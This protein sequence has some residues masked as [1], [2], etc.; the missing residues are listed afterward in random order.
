MPKIRDLTNC[1]FGRLVAIRLTGEIRAHKAMW[2]CRC[3]C[4]NLCEIAGVSLTRG[5]TRSCG[6]LSIEKL[7]ARKGPLSS[8][9][10]RSGPLSSM[11]GRFGPL[12]PR[13]NPELTKEDRQDK[14]RYTEY[15]A[16][17]TSVYKRDNFTCQKCGDSIGG[18]LNAH[19]IRGYTKNPAL[20]TK[21]ENG[22]TLC[23]EC[24][25]DYHHCYGHSGG[26]KEFEKWMK[27]SPIQN[28][29]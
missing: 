5:S 12:S 20:R 27:L 14:R 9:W 3:S 7:K 24:H 8:N 28:S 17:R 6:C 16:W 21:I 18:S 10:G 19:H 15:Y 25:K 4:G 11:W 29:A 2:L 23:K 26:K 1:K 13:W 22:I